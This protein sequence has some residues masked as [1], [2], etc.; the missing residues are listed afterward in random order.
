MTGDYKQLNE[1]IAFQVGTETPT[2]VYLMARIIKISAK[3][4]FTHSISDLSRQSF[5]S[6]TTREVCQYSITPSRREN[7]G[8]SFH[9]LELPYNS[10]ISFNFPFTY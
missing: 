1:Y 6:W 9:T 2:I 8:A 7:K 5:L 3:G 10:T 4:T